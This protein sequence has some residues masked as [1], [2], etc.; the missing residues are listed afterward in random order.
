MGMQGIS[1]REEEMDS[2]HNMN[3][4][5]QKVVHKRVRLISTL[6]MWQQYRY[7]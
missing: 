5:Q 3:I 7:V 2:G 6:T 4:N 1:E